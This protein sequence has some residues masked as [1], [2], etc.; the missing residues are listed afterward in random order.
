MLKRLSFIALAS[1]ALTCQAGNVTTIGRYA[2]VANKPL[3]AQINPL[4]AIQQVHFPQHIQTIGEAIEHWLKYS[5]FHL[6]S[7]NKQQDC[8]K[9]I[10]KQPLPQ[11]DRNLG[12]MSVANGLTVLV[13]QHLF[14]LKHDDLLREVNFTLI[15]RRKA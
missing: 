6:A 14:L 5:G 2:S 15:K 9:T 12:P 4:Q 10:L 1:L 13:G 7:A 11:V 3:A 8:L